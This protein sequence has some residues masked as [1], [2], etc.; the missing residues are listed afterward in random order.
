M[1]DPVPRDGGVRGVV[2]GVGLAL[3]AVGGIATAIIIPL[4]LLALV[5]LGTAFAIGFAS[6]T[7]RVAAEGNVLI[8]AAIGAACV[9]AIGAFVTLSLA[10]RG[11]AWAQ[12]TLLIVGVGLALLI[13]PFPGRLG[14][15]FQRP[16]DVRF[17]YGQLA[18]ALTPATMALGAALRLLARP[19]R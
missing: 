8:L 7:A 2:D 11:R 13:N 9:A 12:V 4:G 15:D 1:A 5:V 10:L 17:T 16:E 19:R 3:L 6:D 18:L 14:P